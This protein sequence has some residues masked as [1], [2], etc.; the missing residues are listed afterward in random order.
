LPMSTRPP[1]GANTRAAALYPP[2]PVLDLPAQPARGPDRLGPRRRQ[3]SLCAGGPSPRRT[4]LAGGPA[5]AAEGKLAEARSTLQSI[6]SNPHHFRDLLEV[7]LRDQP[8][9]DLDRFAAGAQSMLQTPIDAEVLYYQG[10]ILVFCGKQASGVRLLA[11][12]IS[13]NYCA[14]TA[15]QTDP[16]LAKLR[17]TALYSELLTEAGHCEQ[18]V[19]VESER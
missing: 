5:R 1:A 6:S 14:K 17:S 15:L 16:L 19:V 10:A 8:S 9:A 13:G 12:A 11:G 2:A 4:P 7:C 3:R 18:R